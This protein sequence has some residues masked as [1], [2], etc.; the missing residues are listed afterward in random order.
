MNQKAILPEGPRTSGK[1]ADPAL[2]RGLFVGIGASAGALEALERFF[3]AVPE[4]SGLA[5]VVVQHLDR[6]HPSVLAELLGRRTAMLVEQAEEGVRA[7]PNHVYVIPPN[8]VLTLQRG[9][10]RLAEPAEAGLRTPVD[11]FFRSLAQDQGDGAVGIILSGTGSDGTSGL[12]AIREQGGLTLAQAPETARYEDMPESAIAA[13]LVD[14]ALPVEE[15]PGRLLAHARHLGE[16]QRGEARGLDTE[17]SERLP[18]ICEVL[19]RHTGHDFSRYKPGTLIRR[20]GRRVRLQDTRSVVDYIGQLESSAEEARNLVRDLSIAVTHFFRDP[21][22]FEALAQNTLPAILDGGDPSAVARIWVAGCASGEEAYS[23]AILAREHMDRR[24]ATRPVQVFAT[25]IDRELV[26]TA[27]HGRYTEEICPAPLRRA[28]RAVLRPRGFDVRGLKG[29][30]GYVHVL[31]AQPDQDPPFSSL[32]LI[33][34]R[35][36]LIYLG[37]DLQKKLVPLFHFALRSGG[38][39]LLGPSEDLAAHQEL[40]ARVD[41][42]SRLYRRSDVVARPPELPVTG[43]PVSR[44]TARAP[45]PNPASMVTVPM[46]SQSLERMIREEYAPPCVVV[47]ERGDILYLTGQTSRYLQIP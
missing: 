34:C 9:V 38:H 15:M 11:A 4:A 5:F 29:R 37:A 14:D 20:I 24:G 32:D 35:N 16:I 44:G 3:S 31:G 45:S 40:F 22:V 23:I 21:A 2:Q 26:A 7:Q 36:V 25:D 17:I 18:H 41:R 27:R 33:T 10:L 1:A 8:T 13:G 6:H 19:L 12:R 42:E 43:C 39:L 46:L 47:N 30:A 28:P